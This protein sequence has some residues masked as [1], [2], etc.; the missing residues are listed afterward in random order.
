M[1][2]SEY[3]DGKASITEFE[4][5]VFGIGELSKGWKKRSASIDINEEMIGMVSSHYEGNQFTSG[6]KKAYKRAVKA[7]RNIRGSKLDPGKK[8]LYVME[9]SYGDLKIGIS[10]DPF[11]RARQLTTGSGATVTCLAYWDT[12]EPAGEV[13]SHLLKHYKAFRKEGE[14][15]EPHSFTIEDVASVIP[16]A[17]VKIFDGTKEKP[18]IEEKK[19]AADTE[20]YEYL[21]IKH[22]THKAI[23]FNI[24]GH[25]IWVAKSCIKTLNK[26]RHVVKVRIGLISDKIKAM[27]Q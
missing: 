13:E 17:K 21:H 18:I 1:K 10:I 23:L 4:A 7:L 15:F 25:D 14:W 12:K 8:Y 26:A 9:N 20:E 11:R 27:K 16:C 19:S 3:L 24:L 22:E 5:E 6:G 2:L